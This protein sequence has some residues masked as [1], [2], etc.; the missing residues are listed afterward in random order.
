MVTLWFDVDGIEMDP[1]G[2]IST[3]LTVESLSEEL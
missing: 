2:Q 1:Q 3:N